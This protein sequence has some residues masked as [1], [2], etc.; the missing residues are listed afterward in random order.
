M[1][2]TLKE[3][4]EKLAAGEITAAQAEEQLHNL[5]QQQAD[6]EG[7]NWAGG[8]GLNHEFQEVHT[9]TLESQTDLDL[10][11]ANGSITV[12]TWDQAEFRLEI[13][14][15]V[16]GISKKAAQQMADSVSLANIGPS[17]I[18]AGDRLCNATLRKQLSV[19]M[20]LQLPNNIQAAGKIR[21]ANG[22]IRLEGLS[23]SEIDVASAN[24]SIKVL[25]CSGEKLKVKTVNG[26]VT[27]EGT[28]PHLACSTTNGSVTVANRIDAGDI[29]LSTVNGALRLALPAEQDSGISLEARSVSSRLSVSHPAFASKLEG[30]MRKAEL[31]SNNWDTADKK[32][33]VEMKSVNGGINLTTEQQPP[34]SAAS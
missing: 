32:I 10:S 15:T 2:A 24:G 20:R 22:S 28:M 1:T 8:W 27:F 25:E 23:L 19:S 26:A 9:G 12:E 5:Q 4:L 11:S 33:R 14:K 7:V 31:Q 13:K 16:R 29:R 21:T 18:Q 30:R 6:T 34:D 17:S 3:I